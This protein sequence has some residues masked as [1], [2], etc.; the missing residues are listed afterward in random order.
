MKRRDRSGYSLIEVLV[1][2]AITSIVLLTV[3]TLFYMGRR[4]IYSGKQQTVAVATATQ[5]LE[6]FSTMTAQDLGT[7]FNITDS[8]TLGTVTLQGVAD[9]PSGQLSFD[10]SISRSTSTCTVDTTAPY[11]ISCTD[12]PSAAG[13]PKFLAKWLR[14]L[15][16]QANT[17][18][19]LASP[20]I[21]VVF[22]PRNPTD[23]AK[24]FTTAQFI[25]A[26]IYVSWVEGTKRRR[27]A[28]F[29]TTKVN[30]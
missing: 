6:D 17:D 24:K 20:I 10:N 21:G 16:P 22:T 25:R 19:V 29:D 5:I 7:N 11:A 9:A 14:T 23:G 28:F 3:I 18:S 26:R 27:Y 12:D 13:S 30:R 15:V 4:N 2:I 1:A 8:T